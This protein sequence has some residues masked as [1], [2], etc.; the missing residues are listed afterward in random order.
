MVGH[1]WLSVLVASCAWGAVNRVEGNGRGSAAT[2]EGVVT[3]HFVVG[4]CGAVCMGLQE[5]DVKYP[6]CAATNCLPVKSD[7]ASQYFSH[8]VAMRAVK[9]RA[10]YMQPTSHEVCT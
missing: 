7:A 9:F 8:N 4:A 1:A 3:S 2:W 5:T 6:R 10:S